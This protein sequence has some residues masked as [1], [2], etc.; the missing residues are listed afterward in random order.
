MTAETRKVGDVAKAAG[1]TV[2]TLHHY[3]QIGLLKPSSRSDSG[4]R[5]YGDADLDRL[6]RI[7]LL[8][9]LGLSLTEIAMALDDRRWALRPAM[10]RHIAE[11]DRRLEDAA[12]LRGLL[13]RLQGELDDIQTPP[14]ED[15]LRLLEAM[16]LTEGALTQRISIAV[17]AD[18]EAAS[19]FLVR[20]FG[21]GRGEL[22][23][24][25]QGDVVHGEVHAGDGVIWLHPESSTYR[26]AS[27]KTVG[28][29]TAC[30]AVM[31]DDVDAHHRH[32]LARGAQ[33]EY[34]PVDQPYGFREYS[35][36]DG[37]GGLWSFMQ[38]LAATHRSPRQFEEG[39][40]DGHRT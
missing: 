22:T 17:Y 6:Y 23:R 25:G 2:R 12:R 31:V 40:P 32:A 15:M 34:P 9:R 16:S 7:C 3:D 19:D 24:D 11:L 28:A 1:L 36:R 10:A 38:P 35:A 30:M 18:L 39:T 14:A 21:F 26:L 4:H 13:A 8:R 37:E 20:V 29:A 33:I 27:P 5:L